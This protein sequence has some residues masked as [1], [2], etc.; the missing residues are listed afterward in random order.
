MNKV[1]VGKSS[2]LMW[3]W[4]CGRCPGPFQRALRV[5]RHVRGSRTA[6]SGLC[7]PG[8]CIWVLCAGSLGP[9]QPLPRLQGA[10]LPSQIASCTG[11]IRGVCCHMQ[12]CSTAASGH[13]ARPGTCGMMTTPLSDARLSACEVVLRSKCLV[14]ST[15]SPS[16]GPLRAGPCGGCHP[17][18]GVGGTVAG[19]TSTPTRPDQGLL[20]LQQPFWRQLSS[21]Q[22]SFYC[23]RPF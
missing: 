12:G 21:R 6:I 23:W 4:H 20:R 11:R 3:H 5:D 13:L 8:N 9:K 1:T 14:R 18:P 10:R 7:K 19:S 15:V 22:R 17:R 16:Q 2:G